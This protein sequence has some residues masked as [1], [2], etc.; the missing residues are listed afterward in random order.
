VGVG[1]WL[2]IDLLRQRREDY[3]QSRPQVVSTRSLLRR[4]ALIGAA[5]PAL[6]VLICA[7]LLLRDRLLAAE[8]SALRP[9]EQEHAALQQRLQQS[10]AQLKQ[11]EEQ[12]TEVAT[13]LADVRSSS[14]FLAELQRSIPTRMELDS[15]VVEGEGLTL[16]GEGV[17]E[18]GFKTVNAFLLSLKQSTFLDPASV[19]LEEAVLEDRQDLQRLRYQL[20]ARFAADAAQASA[21]RLPSLG[22]NGM[23]LRIA[24]MRGLGV[25]P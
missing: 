24:L 13:A 21:A 8:A 22:A 2:E 23:A 7:W 1:A 6:L 18:G 3:G 4:G 16:Q 14:A 10:K 19:T 17:P 25:L 12:N 20:K 5:L 11:L 9:A 15:V